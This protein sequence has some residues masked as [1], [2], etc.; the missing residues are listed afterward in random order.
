MGYSYRHGA[1][2]RFNPTEVNYRANL[3][4]LQKLGV[5][6]VLAATA[7][8]SLKEEKKPGDMVILDSFIDR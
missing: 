1:G 8:G 4:A 7:C 3:R 6:H 2:H 5:T